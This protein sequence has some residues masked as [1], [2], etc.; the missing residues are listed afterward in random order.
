MAAEGAGD[1]IRV[2]SLLG[3]AVVAVPLFK[4]I[5]LGSVLGYL[6]AG[7]AIGP[8][9]LNVVDDPHAI[10]HLA[11]FGVVMFL[12]VIGLEMKPSHLWSLRRQ[13]FGLGS[14]QAGGDFCD[15]DD[16]CRRTIRR[17]LGSGVRLL[18]R[19]R[20]NLYSHRN[21]SIGRTQSAF[22]QAGAKNRIDFAF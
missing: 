2:V 13:I 17:L 8:Y 7:L 18:R 11:E 4:R 6:A 1:L 20:A 21:A 10:I 12:F 9:G 19:L 3:A 15:F 14:M 5:G 22:H 16:D